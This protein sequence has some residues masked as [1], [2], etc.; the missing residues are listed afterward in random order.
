MACRVTPLTDIE[1]KKTKPREQ[2]KR[3][4]AKGINPNIESKVNK[5]YN[6]AKYLDERVELM[7][8]WSNCLNSLF[9]VNKKS[10]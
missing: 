7:Q 8:W 10:L 4:I 5:A 3:D 1:I 6:R 9:I 2:L